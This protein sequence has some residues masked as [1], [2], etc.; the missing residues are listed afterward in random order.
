VFRSRFEITENDQQPSNAEL[1]EEYRKLNK[2]RIHALLMRHPIGW[3]VIPEGPSRDR[4]S[5]EDW[6][7]EM[8]ARLD[9]DV[10][11]S[12]GLEKVPPHFSERLEKLAQESL[13]HESA[14]WENSV[15]GVSDHDAPACKDVEEMTDDE[16]CDYVERSISNKEESISGQK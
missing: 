6:V 4:I 15:E 3:G 2:L 8:L 12:F 14:T 16:L 9:A 13:H 5:R 10:I 11:Q 1:R 7:F